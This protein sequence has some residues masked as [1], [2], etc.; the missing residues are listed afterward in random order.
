M[1]LLFFSFLLKQAHG[2]AFFFLN[3][4]TP[5]RLQYYT[6]TSKIGKTLTEQLILD[7]QRLHPAVQLHK[8]RHRQEA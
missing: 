5:I 6:F 8:L 3:F 4:I 1:S 2:T 7:S